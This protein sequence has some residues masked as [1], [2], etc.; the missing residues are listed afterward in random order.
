[1]KLWNRI[2][3]LRKLTAVAGWDAEGA[4]PIPQADWDRVEGCLDEVNHRV[5]GAP[6]PYVTPSE[7]G[8]IW[9]KWADGTHTL[10]VEAEGTDMHWALRR[11]GKLLQGGTTSAQVIVDKIVKI[12]GE[13]P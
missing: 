5:P 1:M 2:D 12:W 9:C 3:H 8:M 6:Y 10:E 7:D 11:D 4:D 13:Y